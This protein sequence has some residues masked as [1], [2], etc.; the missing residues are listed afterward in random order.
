MT[1]RFAS[2]VGLILI[3]I[4]TAWAQQAP[5]ADDVDIAP[6]F[7]L[8]TTGGLDIGG[9]YAE[10]VQFD[11]DWTETEQHDIFHPDKAAGSTTQPGVFNLTGKF[12]LK[13]NSFTLAER[14]SPIDGG[15]DYSATMR[16]DK[17]LISTNELSVA[18]S[19]PVA[20]F[21]GKQIT[22]DQQAVDMPMA[23]APKGEPH[24]FD[25]QDV[26]EIDLH[27]ASGTLV[28]T[29]DFD[30]LV[31][32]DREWGDQRYGLRIHFSPSDG[33]IKQSTIELKMKWKPAGG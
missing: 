12:P 7:K 19:L 32:D 24:I 29:G 27:T 8:R 18:L 22:V 10:V 23:A 16:A 1:I 33:D 6:G 14:I 15:I 5:P 11:P 4:A 31:Q 17:D 20:I 26:H 13:S 9:I 28:I 30:I 2:L 25:S 3:L 21:G